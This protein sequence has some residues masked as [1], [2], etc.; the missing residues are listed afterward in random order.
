MWK[1]VPVVSANRPQPYRVS[2]QKIL[3]VEAG[4]GYGVTWDGR[5]VSPVI[6]GR[7]KTPNLTDL[8][9]TAY[10]AGAQRIMLTGRLP[11]AEPG[12]PHWLMADTPGWRH[13]THWLDTPPTGRYFHEATQP[14]GDPRARPLEVATAAAWFGS[15]RLGIHQARAAWDL[16]AAALRRSEPKLTAL[17]KSPAATGQ[18]LWAL[19]MPANLDP[20]PVDDDVAEEIHRTSGQHHIEHLVAGPSFTDHPDCVPLIDPAQGRDSIEGFAY[21]DGRF[22]YAGLCNELAVGPARRLRGIDAHYLFEESPYAPARYLIRFT[23][24][25]GW[26]HLGVW[27]VKVPGST[28]EWYWPNR[29][30]ATAET[31]VDAAELR[32]GLAHGW[33]PDTFVEAVQF[34]AKKPAMRGD[35]R[36]VA[37]RPLD[38]FAERLQN[39]RE[40]VEIAQVEDAVKDAA[41]T[42]LRAVLLETIGAFASRGRRS[43][44]TVSSTFEVPEQYQHSIRMWGN[45]ITYQAPSPATERQRQFYHPELAAQVWGRARARVL[46]GTKA[47]PSGAL[48]VAP[49]QLIGIN[50][51]ALYTTTVPTWAL[52]TAH[53][54]A[55]D[56]RAGKL[57]LKGVLDGPLPLPVTR[58]QRDALMH[59]AETAGPAA[60][61]QS[62][63]EVSA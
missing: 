62:S 17:M 6:R 15:T 20:A 32:V 34:T 53:G 25:P 52:P 28:S 27:G 39:A 8:L 40:A 13:G 4:T 54:G 23:V 33:R 44:V 16:V 29:P 1:G 3:W 21:L 7:R 2:E 5:R 51:D 14:E 50:G 55:D 49:H 42:A 26:T 30:G 47:A 60:A 61:W 57:R 9:D 59:R 11:T 22:M 36:L 24:P 58:A 18:N 56:G 35:T 46:D 12:R 10:A 48:H 31:W 63:D 45:R 41:R 43:T 19:S 37:A 38:T